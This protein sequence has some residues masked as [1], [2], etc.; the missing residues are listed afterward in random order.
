M[1]FDGT[2]AN[3]GDKTDNDILNLE[4]DIIQ[5]ILAFKLGYTVYENFDFEEDEV[6]K[7]WSLITSIGTKYWKNDVNLK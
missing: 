5:N 6:L 1:F 7:G 3:L 4:H 2:W